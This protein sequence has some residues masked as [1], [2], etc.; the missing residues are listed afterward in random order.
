MTETC[1]LCGDR[2]YVQVKDPFIM[3]HWMYVTDGDRRPCP[4]CRVVEA[5]RLEGA[6]NPTEEAR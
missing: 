6:Q 2:R 4:E 5:R 3:P 1:W